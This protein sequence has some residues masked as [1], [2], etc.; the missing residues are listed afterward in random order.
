MIRPLKRLRRSAPP[1]WRA[2]IVVLV[3]SVVGVLY[4]LNLYLTAR[5]TEGQRSDAE[6]TATFF[7][8]NLKAQLQRHAL[9]PPLLARDPVL[10]GALLSKDYT[11]TSQRLIEF[12]NEIG[13]TA[14]ELYDLDGRIVASTNRRDLGRLGNERPFVT[15]ALRDSGTVFTVADTENNSPLGFHYARRVTYGALTIGL[16]AVSVDLKII[17]ESWRR[18]NARVA[19]T[20]S[21]DNIILAS[22]PYWRNNVI[23]DLAAPS[24]SSRFSAPITLP[25]FQ[26]EDSPFVFINDKPYLRSET[27]V[28]FRGWRLTF[29]SSLE[30]VRAQV[31]LILALVVT[32]LA[33]MVAAV[34]YWLSKRLRL[35]SQAIEQESLEL[36]R[37]NRRLSEEIAERERVEKTLQDAEQSLEQASKLAALGQMSAAVSHEL[38]QPLAA[39]RTYLAGA[40]LLVKRNRV[41]EAESSFLRIDDLIDRMGSITRQL[42]SYARKSTT[43][44]HVVDMRN[45]VESSLSMMAPQLTQSPVEIRKALPST[46]VNVTADPVRLE[47]IIVNLLRNALDAV[48]DCDQPVLDILLVSGK[49]MS[50][51]V[52]DNGTGIADLEN[53]FEPFY[54]TKKPGEGVGL[55]L[56]ISAGIATELG[57]RLSARN[58]TQGGAIFELTLPL[59]DEKQA[60]QTAAE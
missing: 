37:L 55:G 52:R 1:W 33:L 60:N 16:V 57:G 46:P 36:K 38:N 18:R 14:I 20:N 56:A 42:K 6:L 11:S 34:L 10:I 2:A 59:T 47:Q 19:V 15:A 25:A 58:A 35:R 22:N 5:F 50:L 13:T 54:T 39:M 7:A 23:A 32:A 28:G 9:L 41:E 44:M 45:V 21:E 48:A 8:G 17:E 3:L 29:F 4:A 27:R 53:L 40:K 24:P 49:M 43:S 31:N 26:T 30:N 12:S 51:S